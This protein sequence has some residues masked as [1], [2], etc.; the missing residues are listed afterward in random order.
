MKKI[1]MQ[2]ITKIIIISALIII[3]AILFIIQFKES[4]NYKTLEKENKLYTYNLASDIKYNVKLFENSIYDKTTLPQGEIYISSL[5]DDIELSLS[6]KF[7]GSDRAKILGKYNITATVKGNISEQN[8]TKVLW[9]KLFILKEDTEF[10]TF[11][12]NKEIIE[13]LT[14]DYDWYNNLS[15]EIYENTKIITS[16]VIELVMNIEYKIET[17]Y[18]TVNEVIKPTIIIPI[19]SQYFSTIS[20]NLDEKTGDFKIIDKITINPNF[21]MI[22]LCRIIIGFILCVIIALPIFTIKPSEYDMYIKKINI[23]FK[24][25]AKILVG[26][27]NSNNLD[28]DNIFYVKSFEDLIKISDE[29]EKPIFYNFSENI[30]H[31]NKFYIINENTSY[32]YY[33]KHS[34]VIIPS[35]NLENSKNI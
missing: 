18:G 4:R 8:V 21:R 24:N 30:G 14:L 35:S 11:N 7:S 5:V 19:G 16:N 9:S 15:K 31:M 17:K 2:L 27:E 28:S 29:I 25:Y 6:N 34:A 23:I 13:N 1:K 22:I 3:T 32:L 26:I 20:S 12:S 33:I 10:S